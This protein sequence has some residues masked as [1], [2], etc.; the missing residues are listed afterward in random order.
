[1]IRAVLTP[2]LLGF[3]FAVVIRATARRPA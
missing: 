1:M 3:A 2:I